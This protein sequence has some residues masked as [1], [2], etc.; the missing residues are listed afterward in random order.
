MV[1]VVHGNQT[2]ALPDAYRRYL[3]GF[4]QKSLGLKGGPVRLKMRTG[5]NPY[6]GRKNVLS[7]R[8]ARKRKRLL[9]FTRRGQRR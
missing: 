9:E 8:Q 3:A 4:F 1:I 2:D 6:Q 7:P 5:D